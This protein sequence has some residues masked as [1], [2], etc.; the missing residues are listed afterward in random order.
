MKRTCLQLLFICCLVAGANTYVAAQEKKLLSGNHKAV[1]FRDFVATIEAES[2]Y[3]FFYDPA[4]VDSI[5][6][7]A[8]YHQKTIGEVLSQVLS[9]TGL[10]YFV[11]ADSNVFITRN[12]QVQGL[13]SD[14]FVRTGKADSSRLA[15][16][17]DYFGTKQKPAGSVSQANK[18]IAIGDRANG[19]RG[20]RAIITGYVRDAKSGEGIIGASV[21]A[22]TTSVGAVTDQSGYYTIRLLPGQHTLHFTGTGMKEAR[23]QISLHSDGSLNVELEEQIMSLRAVIVHADRNSNVGSTL[24]GVNRLSSAAIRQ[25]PALLGETDILRAVLTLPGVLSVGEASTGFNVRGGAADQNL[26]LFNEATI[27]NPAHLFGFFTAF[28]PDV[29]KGVELYKSGIPEKYGGRLSSVLEVTAKEGNSKK[30][31]GIAGV[32]LL[33]SKLMIEGPIKKD[34]ATFV[35]GGRTT[36]SNWL[37]KNIPEA[38][39][40]NSKASFYDIDAH[41]QHAINDKNSL[42]ITAYTSNDQFRFNKDTTYQYGNRNVNLKWKHIFNNR[43]HSS[44]TVAADEYDYN[45]FGNENLLTGFD[46]KFS[47]RQKA[48]RIDFQYSLA[49]TH[50]FNFGL[51]A[52]HYNVEPGSY[53]PK[54]G[55]SLIIPD[56]LQKEQALESAIYFGDRISFNKRFSV[57][58]GI[59]YSFY[60][61]LGPRDVYRYVPGLPK[62]DI[63]IVD[64][65]SFGAGKA[66]VTYHKPEY[67]LSARYA[68]SDS[69]SVKA[70]FNSLRQYIHMISN[71]TAIAPTDV[72]KLSDT[73][74]KPQDGYQ[75]SI[76]LYK[77][78]KSNQIETSVEL[79][80]KRIR[81]YLD[82]KSGAR[83]TLN[84]HLETD[85]MG[86]EG[87]AYGA[88]LLLKKTT[89]KLN[90]WITYTYSRTL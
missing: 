33:T 56:V 54:G 25:I 22:D 87:K 28:N 82:Y 69:T 84:H 85:V 45:I 24:T 74:I 17:P 1:A 83:L 8:N 15:E 77:N 6:V 7:T 47:I 60:N 73:H 11:D 35:V 34:K 31:Q 32:G 89:G 52:I 21:F 78:F 26:I 10:K 58:A 50:H 80:Y 23:R 37:L 39:Y 65:T 38:A 81:N 16:I 42:A 13:P 27:Y 14:F 55:A 51:N 75:F 66:I 57:N 41:L 12:F 71:T 53:T 19:Q 20:R 36:Y 5:W 9:K 76:G 44:F 4:A 61:Y 88:E 30:I 29:V 43:F 86:T 70:S 90:G 2:T 49:N 79:Y 72:W 68:F 64:T 63:T 62:Q 59:R 18:L 48:F 40:R 3:H 67:R 46:M